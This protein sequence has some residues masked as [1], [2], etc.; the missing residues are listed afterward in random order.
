LS[1]IDASDPFN[2]AA[3]RGDQNSNASYLSVVGKHPDSNKT[4]TSLEDKIADI[5]AVDL[6][7][8]SAKKR[9]KE[10]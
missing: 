9:L 6:Q 3:L 2:A 10:Q 8:D 1:P 4:V 5:K 7:V